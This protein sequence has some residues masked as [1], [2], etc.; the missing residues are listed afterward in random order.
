MNQAEFNAM[1]GAVDEGAQP[2]PTLDD[3]TVA[4]AEVH[5][6]ER[7]F[8]ESARHPSSDLQVLINRELAR[9]RGRW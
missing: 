7:S 2:V 1:I 8:E 3:Y 5:A 4:L 6:R 9:R